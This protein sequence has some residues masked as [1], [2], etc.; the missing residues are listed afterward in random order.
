VD[1]KLEYKIDP[2]ARPGNILGPLAR[3]LLSRARRCREAE[4]KRR[5]V[6]LYDLLGAQPIKVE[7]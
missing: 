3:L 6:R 2:R 5:L 7:T 1:A 4:P